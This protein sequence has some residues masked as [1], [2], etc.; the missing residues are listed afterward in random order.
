MIIDNSTVSLTAQHQTSQS[1]Q[2][3]ES[4]QLFE[5]DQRGQRVASVDLSRDSLQRS[6]QSMTSQA[7]TLAQGVDRQDPQLQA[8]LASQAA[9]PAIPG[10]PGT[11]ATPAVPASPIMP[12]QSVSSNQTDS[13][14]TPVLDPRTQLMKSILERMLGKQIHIGVDTRSPSQA[15]SVASQAPAEPS[16]EQPPAQ[17]SMGMRYEFHQTIE[18]SEQTHFQA[19]GKVR[20]Q[21]G[22]EIDFSLELSMSRHYVDQQSLVIE[23][24][25]R[26]KDPLIINF[27]GRA[28]E[29][30]S[31]RF[32]FDLDA[33]GQ[34]DQIH[35]LASHSGMLA[36]DKNLDGRIND[37]S[38]LFGA[39]SGDGFAD[40][41]QYDDDNNGF[42]DEA[43]NVFDQLQVWIK[44][45]QGNDQLLGLKELDI[46]ALYLGSTATPFDLKGSDNE[47]QGR[48]RAT[49]VYLAESGQAGTLQ[50]IDL[51]T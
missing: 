19:Q 16:A 1:R 5:V 48:I 26:L 22:R 4:L 9:T 15:E 30:H 8:Q 51:V 41:A 11:A 37:G 7:Q 49:G 3:H 2:Q 31:N 44:D 45:D 33:D 27:D 36:L 6:A 20:T 46:G 40:L 42:I 18:E 47:L 13:L 24:G 21:D 17:T 35:Q 43:D 29:L 32:A 14:E 23:A 12:G 25:A 39:L 34:Q 10:E 38:E 28:A 50:Q